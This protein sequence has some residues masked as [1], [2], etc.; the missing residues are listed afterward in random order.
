LAL[1]LDAVA[2]PCC[3]PGLL[4]AVTGSGTDRRLECTSTPEGPAPQAVREAEATAMAAFG[5]AQAAAPESAGGCAVAAVAEA[6]GC[7]AVPPWTL[8]E[9]ELSWETLRSAFTLLLPLFTKAGS[10]VVGPSPQ[11]RGVWLTAA[12]CWMAQHGPRT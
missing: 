3:S 1:P 9:G 6:L 8:G 12:A 5:E 4:C 2:T 11:C 7:R 10:L